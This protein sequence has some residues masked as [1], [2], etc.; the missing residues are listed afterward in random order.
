M[1]ISRAGD[2]MRALYLHPTESQL[3]EVLADVESSHGGKVDFP[4]FI[5]IL[6]RATKATVVLMAGLSGGGA[7]PPE[8]NLHPPEKVAPP[9]NY[10]HPLGKV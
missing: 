10:L 6:V 5:E 8:I 2:A 3:E 4:E 7:H 9:C 1:T